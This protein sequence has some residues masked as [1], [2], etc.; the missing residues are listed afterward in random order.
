MSRG[1]AGDQVRSAAA[2]TPAINSASKSL[3]NTRVSR[4]S[5]VVVA[6]EV[7]EPAPFYFQHPTLTAL[8]PTEGAVHATAAQLI[9]PRLQ[10]VK[11]LLVQ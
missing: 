1:V 4:Q 2:D 5:Q 8:H 9:E 11:A 3:G 6:A 7:E 10:I